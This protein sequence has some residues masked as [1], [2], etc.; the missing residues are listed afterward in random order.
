MSKIVPS[1]FQIAKR[2]YGIKGLPDTKT[3]TAKHYEVVGRKFREVFGEMAGWAHSVC[4][5][6][7][8]LPS[9]P[10]SGV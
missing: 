2:D 7:Y 1:S 8:L 6:I 5:V 4:G 9:F 3:L 10:C